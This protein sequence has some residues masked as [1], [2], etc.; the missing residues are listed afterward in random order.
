MVISQTLSAQHQTHRRPEERVEKCVNYVNGKYLISTVDLGVAFLKAT[1][2]WSRLSFLDISDH[3]Y[4]DRACKPSWHISSCI[5][6]LC[7][8]TSRRAIGF[9][10]QQHVST[11]FSPT[12]L[13]F[14]RCLNSVDTVWNSVPHREKKSRRK[15]WSMPL[16]S[17]LMILLCIM[18][19][20][21]RIF[22]GN[23]WKALLLK[24]KLLRVFRKHAASI[25]LITKINLLPVIWCVC[26][27]H[28]YPNAALMA[29]FV[30]GQ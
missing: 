28:F 8:K 17:S 30:C 11:I 15:M 29:K 5:N 16:V 23:Q 13:R 7:F 21:C 2:N 25:A 19:L 1:P 24:R 26:V 3:S 9:D 6:V 12:L 4:L 18:F 22:T 14:C 27:C 20:C 10:Q